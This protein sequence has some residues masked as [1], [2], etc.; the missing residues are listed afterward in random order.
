MS[1]IIHVEMTISREH[2]R[3]MVHALEAVTRIGLGQFGTIVDT[4]PQMEREETTCWE[5]REAI[6][7]ACKAVVYPELRQGSS[8]GISNEKAPAISKLCYELWSTLEGRTPMQ[9]SGQPIP[10]VKVTQ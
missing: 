1:D 5:R 4:I 6:E 2:Y 3:A 9:V 10:E 7:A 8:Y